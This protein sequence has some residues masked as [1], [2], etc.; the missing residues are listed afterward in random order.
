MAVV[1]IE[2]EEVGYDKQD[3]TEIICPNVNGLMI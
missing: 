2:E 3:L 1:P